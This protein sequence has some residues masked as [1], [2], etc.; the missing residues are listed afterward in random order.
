M[1][2]KYSIGSLKRQLYVIGT[3]HIIPKVL[4]SDI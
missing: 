2:G 1:S 3:S 4:Q